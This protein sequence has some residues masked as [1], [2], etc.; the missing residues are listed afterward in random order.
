MLKVEMALAKYNYANPDNRKSKMD[1]ARVIWPNS[2]ETS[3]RVLLSKLF[4]GKNKKI[5]VEEVNAIC[6]ELNCDPNFLFN[7]KTND[8]HE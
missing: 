6:N 4:N 1:L 7:Y 8:K 2:P 5:S 3:Q